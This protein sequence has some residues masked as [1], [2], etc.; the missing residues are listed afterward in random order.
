[1]AV[2][3]QNVFALLNDDVED[4]GANSV[5]TAALA[6]K[7]PAPASSSNAAV[8]KEDAQQQKGRQPGGGRGSGRG[9]PRNMG[10]REREQGP[11]IASTR[12]P[13]HPRH[14]DRRDHPS[15]TVP[16]RSSNRRDYDRKSGTGRGR[17]VA[18]RG[19][20]GKY[21]YG[22]DRN[23]ARAAEQSANA[24][25]SLGADEEG[26]VS[27][28]EQSRGKVEGDAPVEGTD[29][30][31]ENPEATE[32]AGEGADEEAEAE[33]EG[34]KNIS[35]EEY[36]K[37]K[38]EAA[39]ESIG[40]VFSSGKSRR[41]AN[42]GQEFSSMK[43]L[44]KGDNVEEMFSNLGKGKGGKG[45]KGSPTEARKGP[46]DAA[47]DFFAGGGSNSRRE[48]DNAPRRSGSG[49][50]RD[51]GNR[52]QRDASNRDSAPRRYPS[53]RQQRQPAAPNMDDVSAFPSLGS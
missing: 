26:A 13:R 32:E 21:V 1:M 46:R 51:G 34:E 17:E 49:R 30:N 6:P 50:D 5:N 25:L 28:A 31:V 16:V 18:K 53:G 35:L 20:G 2:V 4:A 52:E 33:A 11:N 40:N 37:Q 9:K 38:A 45:K 41:V 48:R 8:P 36:E 19:A 29:P 3:G 23:D 43:A 22:N 24:A 39:A 27:A 12:E 42:D 14:S 44:K 7:K 10:P 47:A 15:S